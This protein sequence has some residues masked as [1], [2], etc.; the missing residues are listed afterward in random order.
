MRKTFFLFLSVLLVLTN[1]MFPVEIFADSSLV[2][3]K[4]SYSN[5]EEHEYVIVDGEKIFLEREIKDGI[6]KGIVKNEKGKSFLS[7]L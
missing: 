1:V 2:S 6:S 3:I 5:L 7:F 4:D